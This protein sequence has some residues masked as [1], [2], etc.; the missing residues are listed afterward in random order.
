VK[1]I[2][3]KSKDAQKVQLNRTKG[4]KKREVERSIYIWRMNRSLGGGG[5]KRQTSRGEEGAG[6]P[7]EPDRILY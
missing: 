1:L 2:L 4:G 3:G 5:Q 7:K 6:R